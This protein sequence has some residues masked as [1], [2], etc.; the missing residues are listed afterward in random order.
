MDLENAFDKVPREAIIL[1]IRLQMVPE[2]L[3]TA[4][5]GLYENSTSQVRFVGGLSEKFPIKV[6][7]NQGSALNSL[8]F[9]LMMEEATKSIGK[10]DPRELFHL[11]YWH[12]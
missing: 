6:S 5:I 9:K 2:C 11:R 4:V 10:G 7:V 12:T 1:A 8:F 3:V